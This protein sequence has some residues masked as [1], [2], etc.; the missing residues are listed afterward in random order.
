MAPKASSAVKDDHMPQCFKEFTDDAVESLWS[1]LTDLVRFELRVYMINPEISLSRTPDKY[2]CLRPWYMLR[3][4]YL[5]AVFPF[6]KT[7]W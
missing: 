3:N 1:D 2:W 5:Y 4:N 6:D 7:F